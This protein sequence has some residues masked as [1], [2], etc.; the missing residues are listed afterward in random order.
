MWRV[1]AKGRTRKPAEGMNQ[2]EAEYAALLEKRRA[3]GEVEWYAFEAIKLRLAK[4][5]FLTL[6]FAVMLTD[7]SFEMHEVK[8][9]FW[10][11]DARVKIKVAA[12]MFPFRIIAAQKLPKKDGG[13]WKVEEF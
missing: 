10:E 12:E 6:D 9:G 1:K 5:T 8:G 4:Q 11:D 2:T 7:G 13:G 3:I